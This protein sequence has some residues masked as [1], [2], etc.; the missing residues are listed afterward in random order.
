MFTFKP[1]RPHKDHKDHKATS[2]IFPHLP[3]IF[4]PFPIHEVGSGHRGRGIRGFRNSG[5]L[6]WRVD[7]AKDAKTVENFQNA[8]RKP[9]LE[10]SE[11][12]HSGTLTWT[13]L[14]DI[15][16]ISRW[17]LMIYVSVKII[18]IWA[19]WVW[20]VYMFDF[21]MFVASPC[22]YSCQSVQ[23]YLCLL[24]RSC[25]N[26]KVYSKSVLTEATTYL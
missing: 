22:P 8:N 10:F 25:A 12:G 18:H 11:V 2:H 7:R 16:M 13:S 21:I 19:F 3:T 6:A 1:T 17:Y 9:L 24:L 15:S 26:A 23:H 5:A 4:P 20:C 14:S